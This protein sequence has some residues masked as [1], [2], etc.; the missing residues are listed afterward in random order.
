VFSTMTALR[1]ATKTQPGVIGGAVTVGDVEVNAGD[2]VIGDVDGVV[3][4]PAELLD[5]VQAAAEQRA[6][7]EQR[8]FAALRAGNTTVDLLQLDASRIARDL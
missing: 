4:I 3:C 5:Q 6:A 7:T 1:G 8:L 2:W